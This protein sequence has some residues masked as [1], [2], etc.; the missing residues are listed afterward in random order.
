LYDFFEYLLKEF[1]SHFKLPY[2]CIQRTEDNLCIPNFEISK[3]FDDKDEDRVV[4]IVEIETDDHLSEAEHQAAVY[5][6]DVLDCDE[7][8][9]VVLSMVCSLNKFAFFC[10]FRL[11]GSVT[12]IQISNYDDFSFGSNGLGLLKLLYILE[13][14]WPMYGSMMVNKKGILSVW[15]KKK[16]LGSGASG[17]VYEYI[18]NNGDSKV[19]K[20]FKSDC[21]KDFFTEVLIYQ[22][23]AEYN[24]SLKMEWYCSK[25]L[26]F[27]TS[28]V[29]QEI[30]LDRINPQAVEGL[31][32]SL[33]T[34]HQVTGFVHRDLYNKNILQLS[35]DKLVLNDFGLAVPKGKLYPIQGNSFFAS[36]RVLNCDETE[37]EYDICDDIY[38]L[39][40]SFI[41]L[42]NS[43]LFFNAFENGR[44]KIISIRE[45]R[46]QSVHKNEYAIKALKASENNDYEEAK[47]CIV[48]YLF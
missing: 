15:K 31:Y 37:F 39:T 14:P 32:D 38:S 25:R 21:D 4:L 45:E 44:E 36:N 20:F 10:A 5:S 7:Q 17:E 34:F 42:K 16:L 9:F 43:F 1:F 23:L 27:C 29:G 18:D 30:I 35:R 19:I 12:F 46:I 8:R 2:K 47:R 40:F 48:K 26:I 33:R 11:G 13:L 41:Y 24:I 28:E 22:Y 3:K 6:I